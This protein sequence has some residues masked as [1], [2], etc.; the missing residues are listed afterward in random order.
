[1]NIKT[2][3]IFIRPKSVDLK[4]LYLKVKSCLQ[5][6]GVE[7]LCDLE[8]AKI[9][10][11]KGFDFNYVCEKSDI[12]ISIGGD[13]TLIATARKSILHQK[14]ILGISAGRLGFLNTI[15]ADECES[16]I[17]KIFKNDFRIDSRASLEVSYTKD[18]KEKIFYAINDIVIIKN[19]I[20][21]MINVDA[22]ANDEKIDSYYG[23]GVILATP[24]GSTAYNL[25]AN[26]AILYP[27]LDAF[28][29]NPICSHSLSKRS[30]VLPKAFEVKLIVSDN[31]TVVLDGQDD[32]YL[33]KNENVVVK[34]SP[35]YAKMIHKKEN[36]YFK[37]LRDKLNWGLS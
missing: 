31:A 26:G 1:L 20:K 14:P 23:D 32:I 15:E 16:F 8:S 30:I 6:Y 2:V 25:S 21:S 5:K 18:S 11:E 37:T 17:S 33:Q 35:L 29:L 10:Q 28:I 7:V 34:I 24:T 22:Y 4:T 9:T 12:L 3:G 19:S 36:T 13:G 27:F